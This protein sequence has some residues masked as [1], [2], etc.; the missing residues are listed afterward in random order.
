MSVP[1]SMVNIGEMRMGMRKHFVPV[2]MVMR[3]LAIPRKAMLML[4]VCVVTVCMRV[5]QRH[6]GMRMRVLFSQMQPNA[7]PHQHRCNPENQAR[8]IA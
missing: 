2:G 4:V 3:L 8:R 5:R 7:G 6:M 1:V